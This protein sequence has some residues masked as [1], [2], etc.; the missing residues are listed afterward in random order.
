MRNRGQDYIVVSADKDLDMTVGPHLRFNTKNE[1][2]QYDISQ[3]QSDRNYY[4][5]LLVG[6]MTDNIQHPNGVGP[7]KANKLLD[8]ATPETWKDA[9]EAIYKEKCGDEWL[10]ALYFTG[11]L[12]HIQRHKDDMFDWGERGSWYE[13]DFVGAPSCYNY[14]AAMLGK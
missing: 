6:D 5:Q 2:I 1:I 13:Q 12:I 7:V 11:S 10:H 14:T 3:G 4:Y 9:V 8:E